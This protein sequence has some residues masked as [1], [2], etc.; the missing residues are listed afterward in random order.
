VFRADLSS[1]IAANPYL[2]FCTVAEASGDLEFTWVD[3]EGV[4]GSERRSIV[5]GG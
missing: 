5:V 2:Q 3:D 1:G 4:R